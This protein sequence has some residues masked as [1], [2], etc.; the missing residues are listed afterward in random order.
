MKPEREGGF[1]ITKVHHLSGRIF[2]RKLQEH[3]IEIGTGQGRVLFALWQQDNVPISNLARRTALGKSTLTDLLDRLSEAGLVKRKR[4]PTDRRSLLICLTER[5]RRM[6]DK[7]LEV[8]K[9][10]TNLFYAGFTSKE[11]TDFEVYLKRILSN[12]T[13]VEDPS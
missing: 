6:Q 13:T 8:S 11:M 10:M 9:E 1:L 5:T 3:G 2:S 4:N 7:Y 12:L